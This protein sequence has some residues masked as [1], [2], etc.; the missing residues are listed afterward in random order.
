MA[1]YTTM[2]SPVGPLFLGGSAAGIH[3]L[4]FLEPEESRLRTVYTL[5]GSIAAL[6]RDAGEAAVPDANAA[7]EAVRQLREYFEGARTAF[8]LPLAPRGT[9]FQIAVWDALTRIPA[10]ET[11]SYGGVASVVGVP[12]ASRAVGMANG[13]NPIAIVVP[14]HRVVGADGTLTGYGG[15]LHRKRW[16]LEHESSSMPLFASASARAGKNC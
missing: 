2:E 16:L 13:R 14:C 3:R 9:L 8:D 4:V 5:D 7:V 12:S 6:E 15:G 11:R 10:G 1:F